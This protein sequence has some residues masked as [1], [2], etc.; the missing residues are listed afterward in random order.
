MIT[1]TDEQLVRL[2]VGSEVSISVGEPWDFASGDGQGVLKGRIVEVDHG[3]AGQ[4]LS[5][6]LKLLVTPFEVEGKGENYTVEYLIARRRY[7]DERRLIEQIASG[8]D[9]D[10]NLGYEDQVPE[11]CLAE[12]VS[13][14]L[15]GGVILSEWQ[16]P[17]A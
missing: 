13:P 15:I 8:Q 3:K 9:V 16:E 4:P 7:A 2:L 12:G 1:L 11:E 5:Q 14:F 10:A 6:T 17:E